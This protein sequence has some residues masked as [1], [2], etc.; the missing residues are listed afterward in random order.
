M[1]IFFVLAVFQNLLVMAKNLTIYMHM[2]IYSE[3]H[4]IM[5]YMSLIDC[6]RQLFAMRPDLVKFL[7]YPQTRSL[8]E[9]GKIADI[10]DA[11]AWKASQILQTKWNLGLAL[12]ADGMAI[13][14]KTVNYSVW[15]IFISILNFPPSIRVKLENLILCGLYPGPQAPKSMNMFF[16]PLI[17][18]L[19]T[20][21]KGI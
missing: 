12:N 17:K 7:E 19:R 21:Y 16:K 5:Y 10:Q 13:F 11:G 8:P 20:L 6:L 15:P 1:Y 9:A 4:R 3:P 2:G 14:G 18:E